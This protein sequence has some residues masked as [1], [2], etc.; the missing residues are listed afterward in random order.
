MTTADAGCAAM[1]PDSITAART[2]LYRMNSNIASA[3]FPYMVYV[4]IEWQ[5]KRA[6]LLIVVDEKTPIPDG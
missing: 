1:S 2:H 5:P 3:S 4:L 6:L